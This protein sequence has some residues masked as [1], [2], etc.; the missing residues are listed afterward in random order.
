MDWDIQATPVCNVRN[1][2]A[3]IVLLFIQK[4]EIGYNEPRI[5]SANRD[6]WCKSLIV[7][8]L[9]HTALFKFSQYS[10]LQTIFVDQKMIDPSFKDLYYY[11]NS[12]ISK[13]EV[14]D[15]VPPIAGISNSALMKIAANASKALGYSEEAGKAIQQ[16]LEGQR[17]REGRKEALDDWTYTINKLMHVVSFAP[18]FFVSKSKITSNQ[19]RKLTCQMILYLR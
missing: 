3:H 8:H 4:R 19:C 17:I 18:P 2:N 16:V 6:G 14:K 15:G 5:C 9:L 13:D 11:Y 10:S 1:R 7:L 12:A